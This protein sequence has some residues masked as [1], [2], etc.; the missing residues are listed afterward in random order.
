MTE[1]ADSVDV[2][3]DNVGGIGFPDILN[4]LRPGGK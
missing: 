1:L 2:V 3:V 4:C